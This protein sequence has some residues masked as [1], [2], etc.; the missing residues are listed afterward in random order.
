MKYFR[1][2]I[3]FS[4]L[5]CSMVLSQ[6]DMVG[7]WTFDDPMNLTAA[8]VGNALVL[9][10][11]HEAVDGPT[12]DDG[13][14]R[15]G[16]GSYYVLPH[17]LQPASGEQRVNEF[18]LVMDIKIPTLG[19]WYCMYQTDLTNTDD[20]EWFI[21]PGG[22]MGVGATGY[23]DALFR[24][25]EWFRIGIAVKNG[26]RYDYYVD[27]A[28]A[29]AGSPGDVDGRF[30]LAPA[31]L[32]FADQNGED[33]QLDV[34]DVKLFSRALSDSEMAALGGYEHEII[35]P[36][37]E[38]IPIPYLQTPT[39]TSIYVCWH[40]AAG[41][42]SVVEYGPTEAL[43]ITASGD[44][45]QFNPS[46]VWHTVK[47]TGLE[48]ET[49]YY[50]RVRTD[51]VVSEIYR[52]K[53]PPPDGQDSGHIRFAVFGD[54]RTEPDVF[55]WVV[56]KLKEKAQALYGENIEEHLNLIFDVGDIVTSG[57]VLHQ[58]RDEYFEPL[59]SVSPYVPTMVS[60][61]NHE[62]E[63][64]YYY[65]YMKYEDLGGTEGEKY[66]SFR[67]GRV[68]FVAINSN[69]QLR[70][71]AQIAWL[72]N[73]LQSAQEDD[74]IDWIFAFCHHP[75][76]SEI[77]PDGNTSYVQ[78]RV[79]PTLKK[80]SKV[81]MLSY[82]H[83]H[84][85]E[86]GAVPDG[87]LRLMLDGGAGSALDRWRMY[88]NQQDY[89]EIQRAFDHYCYTIVDIDIAAKK[90]KATTYSMGHPDKPLDNEIIDQFIRDKANETPPDRPEP[91][92]PLNGSAQKPPFFLQAAHYDGKYEI[93]SSH[94]QVTTVQGNYDDP[95][96]DEIRD[97]ENIYGDTGAPNYDPIDLNKGIDLEKF[98][99]T[100]VNLEDGVTYW[101]RV[102]YRDRNLQW[103][104]WSDEFSF[105]I[106]STT[107]VE[108]KQ[109]A[110]PRESRLYANFPNPFNPETAI[111]FDLARAGRVLLQVFDTN[112]RLV[113]TLVDEDLPGGNHN[114]TWNGKDESGL[115]LPS[116][117]YF[118][119][120]SVPG[121]EKTLKAVLV[122]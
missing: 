82:G 71:D 70:N 106:G 13:A 43:G 12:P 92:S 63:A 6:E 36:P 100:G 39:P 118:Y 10:G 85:Y 75:G 68:L 22:S 72:D 20:G 107:G 32:L 69:R 96:I 113:R 90:Y 84:N 109:G 119:H 3:L 81:D 11:T 26:S 44:A 15:I 31:V 66:Y 25:N 47:L 17:G 2:T 14:V 49:F 9:T 65:D 40:S 120:L 57:N 87:N 104:E 28:R 79:I 112:G 59:N 83:S 35:P 18:S 111:E 29:L 1:M 76:H 77:W 52:F 80:Y 45:H 89:P 78:N 103:S 56:N 62:G 64:Q 97:Y 24:E 101:W 61:G 93:M 46:T 116:G 88:S 108:E 67:L 114:L 53:T 51:T 37:A 74:T 50:Y 30:S 110:L 122:K 95:V 105:T 4:F 21:N 38:D 42:E 48:P 115:P 99:I 16:V 54:N 102:R 23:T 19:R 60:I 34:A 98:M 58:Y 55:A 27:G 8:E 33:N 91:L 121:Y 86:R 7:H 5:F 73:L 117:V 94:F 41:L